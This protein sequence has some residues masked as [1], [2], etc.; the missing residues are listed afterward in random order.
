MTTR[1]FRTSTSI[2]TWTSLG[3]HSRASPAQIVSLPPAPDVGA[4]A[5]DDV[6]SIV[7]SGARWTVTTFA[8]R[9]TC[10]GC[11]RA[12]WIPV[13]VGCE[14]TPLPPWALTSGDEDTFP[15]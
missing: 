9:G 15:E 13:G 10:R 4:E 5:R 1:E 12:E 3:A 6:A 14:C 7:P 8:S 2:P 11:S